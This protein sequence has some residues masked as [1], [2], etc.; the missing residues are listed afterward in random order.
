MGDVFFV[1]DVVFDVV[2]ARLYQGQLGCNLVPC[3]GVFGRFGCIDSLVG[4]AF[5]H[6]LGIG[7]VSGVFAFL[8][9]VG[10]ICCGFGGVVGVLLMLCV[11]CRREFCRCRLS[12]SPLIVMFL[13]C[14]GCLCTFGRSLMLFLDVF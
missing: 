13:M 5:R 4:G 6:G 14:L 12:L 3:V 7:G 1:F 2:P 10:Q 9:V 11:V 8:D